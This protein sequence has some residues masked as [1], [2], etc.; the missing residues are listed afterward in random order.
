MYNRNNLLMWNPSRKKHK[1]KTETIESK[2]IRDILKKCHFNTFVVLDLDDTVFEADGQLGNAWFVKLFEHGHSVISNKD[3]A[4]KHIIDVYNLV[5]EHITF[6]LVESNTATIIKTLQDI[7]IPVIALTAREPA[8]RKIVHAALTELD[9]DLSTQWQ[10]IRKIQLFV[11]TKDVA[12]S[13]GVIYCNGSNNKGE[14]LEAFF[15]YLQSFYERSFPQHILMIDDSYKNLGIVQKTTDKL[16]SDFTG[17]HY[18]NLQEK[19]AQFKWEESVPELLEISTKFPEDKQHLMKTL[20]IVDDETIAQMK[21]EQPDDVE[22]RE[23]SEPK[24]MKR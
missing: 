9:I 20:R 14:A 24:R 11:G 16:H 6:K 8:N 7:N 12:F 22:D 23:E 15:T 10:D 4:F 3:E 21:R 5:Q 1:S 2:S 17:I 19:S 18:T 13:K